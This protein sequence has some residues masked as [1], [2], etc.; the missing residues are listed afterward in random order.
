MTRSLLLAL[1]L[2]SAAPLAAQTQLADGAGAYVGLHSLSFGSELQFGVDATV[3]RR[4]QSGLDVGLRAGTRRYGRG[5]YRTVQVSPSLGYT[6]SLGGGTLGRVQA[7]ADYA[8]ASR[9][10]QSI[11]TT[12]SG[13]VK[14]SSDRS[15]ARL[16]GLDLSAS[17]S[18]PVRLAG[19][20]RV[21]PTVG[22]YATAV[23]AF[24]VRPFADGALRNGLNG[25]ETAYGLGVELAL[26]VSF[27]LFGADA[28]VVPTAR[29]QLAGDALRLQQAA[30]LE[31]A[32]GLGFRLNF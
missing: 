22:G 12:P 25:S 11:G 2:A 20:L 5:S 13:E 16:A 21:H 8:S 6:G 26:P 30:G 3:G 23:R 32:G 29:L 15:S 4:Y 27:R 1:A 28:A 24:D 17:V 31:P 14:A 10:I 19:S 9:T 7:R 18:R